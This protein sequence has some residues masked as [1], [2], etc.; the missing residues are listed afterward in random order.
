MPDFVKCGLLAAL[1]LVAAPAAADVCAQATDADQLACLSS[2]LDTARADLDLAYRAALAAMPAS[3]PGDRRKSR[4]QLAAAETAW[5][6]YVDANCAYIG[7]TEGGSNAFVSNFAAR[8]ELDETA[9]RT[10]FLRR[11]ATAAN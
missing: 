8:C 2:A 9:K 3:D 5:R 4:P 6:A 10:A 1:A 11:P 7:G